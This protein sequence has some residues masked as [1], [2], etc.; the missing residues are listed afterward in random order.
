[1]PNETADTIVEQNIVQPSEGESNIDAGTTTAPASN[2]N[3]PASPMEFE[4]DGIGKVKADEIKEWKLGHMRQSDY[5]KKTQEIAKSKNENKEALELY[6]Y[7]KN[8]PQ[9]AT[10]LSQGD[11]SVV[12]NNQAFAKLNPYTTQV[13]EL[14]YKLATIELDSTLKDMKSKYNDFNEVEVLQEA[15]RLGITDLEFVY[16]ALNGKKLPSLK[17]Q[18]MKEIK[19]SLTDEIR[20]NGLATQTIM[21]SNDTVAKTEFG[22]SVDEKTMAD[23]M[24]LTYEQYS[25]GKR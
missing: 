20:K 16:N 1:M 22:L 15:D 19:A 4:I 14:N 6:N 10:A 13:E 7:L 17:E 25:K 12:Q 5:T 9:I 21:N 18:M 8:N 23:K 24:G 3:V 2:E 11:M